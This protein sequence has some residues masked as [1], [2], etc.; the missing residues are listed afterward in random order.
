MLKTPSSFKEPDPQ[1][2]GRGRGG[3]TGVGLLAYPPRALTTW[4]QQGLGDPPYWDKLS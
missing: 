2:R 1:S 3:K 4:L